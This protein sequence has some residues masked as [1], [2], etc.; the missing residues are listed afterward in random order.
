A[1]EGPGDDA[2]HGVLVGEHRAGG[3][4]PAVQLTG[5]DGVHVRRELEDGV[6]GRVDDRV[7][8][9]EVPGAVL[10]DRA[11]ALDGLVAENAAAGDRPEGLDHLGRKAARIGRS[12]G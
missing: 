7:A 5:W 3:G 8:G 6:L 2:S 1:L 10:L 11:Q 9:L 12:A 4:A